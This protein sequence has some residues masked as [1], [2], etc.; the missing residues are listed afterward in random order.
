MNS[1]DCDEYCVNHLCET[2]LFSVLKEK[3]IEYQKNE[4]IIV[5]YCNILASLVSNSTVSFIDIS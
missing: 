3:L 1:V 5:S 2:T 4:S